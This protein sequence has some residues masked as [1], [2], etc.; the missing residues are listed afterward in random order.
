MKMKHSAKPKYLVVMSLLALLAFSSCVKDSDHSSIL[1]NDPQDIPF[2]TDYLPTDLL[3]MFGEDY[4]FFGDQPPVVDMEFVSN[5]EYVAT[6]L[7]PPYAPPVGTV[8]PIRHFHKIVQQY[9]QIA[10]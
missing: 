2:I 6:S 10:D 9:L 3:E 5:H 8:T 1:F 7:Q 4:V